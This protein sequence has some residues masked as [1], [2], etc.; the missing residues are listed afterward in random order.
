MAAMTRRPTSRW[1]QAGIAI[2]GATLLAVIAFKITANHQFDCYARTYPHDGQDGLGAFMDGLY[3]GSA[4]ELI[5]FVLIFGIQVA[6]V[7]RAKS[8][9]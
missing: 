6:F 5:G 2:L 7:S 9:E 1:T 8:E 3:V 4:T